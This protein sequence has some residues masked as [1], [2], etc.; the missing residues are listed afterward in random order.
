MTKQST[1]SVTRRDDHNNPVWAIEASV[2]I[3]RMDNSMSLSEHIGV[4]RD[5]KQRIIGSVAR[6]IGGFVF[7]VQG[8]SGSIV[9]AI[10]C[11]G[12]VEQVF[13]NRKLYEK[14]VGMPHP[15]SRRKKT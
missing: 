2:D 14:A 12:L 7:T 15:K 8:K 4:F 11:K 10:D 13:A 9:L 5:S 3:I 6:A 1:P